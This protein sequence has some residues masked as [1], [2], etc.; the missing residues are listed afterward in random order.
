MSKRKI[1]FILLITLIIM[2]SARV[3]TF[4]RGGEEDD[5][6][7]FDVA[8][9]DGRPVPNLLTSKEAI[10]FFQNRINRNPKDPVSY[11]LL[12]QMHVRRARETGEVAGYGRAEAALQKA[13]EIVPEYPAAKAMLASTLHSLHRFG[14]ALTLAKQVREQNPGNIQALATIGDA[15]VELGKYQEANEAYRALLTKSNTPPV[16]VRLA[17]LAELNGNTD[18]ALRLTQRAGRAQ[19]NAGQ[20]GESAAW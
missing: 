4:D 15:Y 19:L 11:S 13:L 14:E 20:S 3:I 2:A 1:V 10:R 12:G 8:R 16:L 5:P 18:E 9:I 7:K 17:H 6:P